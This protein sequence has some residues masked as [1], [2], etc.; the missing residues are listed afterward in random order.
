MCTRSKGIS[1]GNLALHR[2]DPRECKNVY[3]CIVPKRFGPVM[4]ASEGW[5]EV[6]SIK[7]A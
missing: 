6:F 3:M 4:W 5:L 1:V 7:K 2:Y